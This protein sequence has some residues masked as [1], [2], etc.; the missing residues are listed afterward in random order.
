DLL[1]F[2]C[3][4]PFEQLGLYEFLNEQYG[5]DWEIGN[6]AFGAS[7]GHP[8]IEAVIKN[9]IRRHED[10]QWVKPMLKTIPRVFRR[11]YLVLATTGPGLVSRTLAA[12]PGACDQVKVLFPQ[13]V[14]DQNSWFRFGDYGVHLQVGT[15]R[16]KKSLVPRMLHRYWEQSIRKTLL[17]E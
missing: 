2:G 5:M 9:C 16:E 6:Y 4:F 1:E 7:A 17:K 12:Y 8:F 3:V 14:C 11:E 10:P 13:D 15:W